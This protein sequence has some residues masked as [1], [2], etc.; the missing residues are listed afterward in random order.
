MLEPIHPSSYAE[1]KTDDM[2]V[3]IPYL[4][5]SE[6]KVKT[7]TSIAANCPRKI[8]LVTIETN[9]EKPGEMVRGIVSRA[10]FQGE[11]V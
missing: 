7:V 11:I 2:T 8:I 10:K 9:R 6:K 4:V 3:V 5:C 1:V